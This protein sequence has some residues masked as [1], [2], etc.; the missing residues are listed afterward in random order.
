MP[1][2]YIMMAFRKFTA[3]NG[4]LYVIFKV[5]LVGRYR[6]RQNTTPVIGQ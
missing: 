5:T 4:Q 6:K 2:N 1:M 3:I